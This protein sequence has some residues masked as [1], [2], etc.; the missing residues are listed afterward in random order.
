[1]SDPSS[2]SREPYRLPP[3]PVR[4]A[5]RHEAAPLP[6]RVWYASYGSNMHARRLGFYL[7]GGRPPH[8]ARTYPGCRD[9]TPP[10]R[11]L[12]IALPG[13]VYFALE[14]PAWTGGL[15]L[16]DPLEPGEAAGRAY[17]VTV[18]QFCDLAAQEMY[19]PPGDDLDITPAVATGTHSVGPGRYETLVCPGWIDGHPVVTFTAPWRGADVACRAPSKPYLRLLGAGLMEAHGWSRDRAGAYLSRCR[20]AAGIWTADDIATLLK[21]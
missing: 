12:P 7:R 6:D 3:R 17:L 10:S 13:R 16:Y 2:V 15:A 19:R 8:A 20:G 1:L 9:A 4:Y 5:G 21:F 11:T 18:A 14:S